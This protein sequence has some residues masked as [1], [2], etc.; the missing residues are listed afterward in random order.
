MSAIKKYYIWFL[1]AFFAVILLWSAYQPASSDNWLLENQLVVIFIGVIAALQFKIHL[2]RLSLTLIMIFMSLHVIGAHYNYGSVPF[3]MTVGELFGL[4]HNAYDKFVH[5]SFGLLI[6]YPFRELL[7]RIMRVQGLWGY[8]LPVGM[9]L[10]WSAI[11][12][13]I[14]WLNVSTIDPALGYL[15]IGGNDPFDAQK[16]ILIAGIGAIITLGIIACL[17]IY[18]D[19][20]FWKKIKTSITRDTDEY[21]KED[22]FIHR[23]F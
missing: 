6:A 10:S 18:H 22:A 13:V 21:P 17:H 5:F 14:E 9:V 2:S 1:A 3:G 4:A 11:Y 16:D 15:Y 8:V 19:K 12:E 20:D 7:L 23:K